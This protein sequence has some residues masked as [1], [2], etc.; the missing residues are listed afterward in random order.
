MA[1]V[2]VVWGIAPPMFMNFVKKVDNVIENLAYIGLA[3]P[4]S[5]RNSFILLVMVCH[6]QLYFSDNASNS[7]LIA[8]IIIVS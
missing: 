3:W 2:E 6:S 7:L 8:T 1:N 5:T 4:H